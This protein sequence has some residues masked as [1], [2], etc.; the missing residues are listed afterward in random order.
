MKRILIFILL[1]FLG[2]S[3]LSIKVNANVIGATFNPITPGNQFTVGDDTAG[4]TN[5]NWSITINFDNN[6]PI[7][8]N[9]DI[10]IITFPLGFN[11]NSSTINITTN[12]IGA[13][14]GV[15]TKSLNIINI[16]VTGNQTSSGQVVISINNSINTTKAGSLIGN[17]KLKRGAS[18]IINF[19]NNFKVI[20]NLI[21]NIIISP[22]PYNSFVGETKNFVAESY[23]AYGNKR[24]K[25]Q[26]LYG[27]EDKFDWSIIPISDPD[28]G[29]AI[30][31]T[32]NTNTDN[33][34]IQMTDWGH[35]QLKAQFPPGGSYTIYGITDIYIISQISQPKVDVNPP[36][37]GSPAE[38][39]IRFNLGPNGG[40]IGGVDSVTI[41]FPFDTFIP[42]GP[43]YF[44]ALINGYPVSISYVSLRTIRLIFPYSLSNG[45]FVIITFPLNIGIINPSKSGTYNLQVYTSKEP[46]P[47]TSLPYTI[48]YSVISRPKVE[49][50]PNVVDTEAKY[51]I[52]FNTGTAGALIKDYDVITIKFPDDTYIPGVADKNEVTI[53]GFN[54]SDLIIS[55]GRKITLKVSINISN[56]SSV[57]IV[58]TDKFGIKNPTK[59]GDYT[60]QVATSR[61]PTFITSYSYKI[62]ESII[63]DLKVVVS[64]PVTKVEAEYKIS[65]KTGKHGSLLE[66]EEIYLKFPSY[67]KLPNEI[68][69]NLILVNGINLTKSPVVDNSNKILTIKIP[70]KVGN[71]EK[72][73]IIISKEAGIKNPDNPGE[74]RLRAWTSKEKTEVLSS[75]YT[76]IESILSS[77]STKAIPP[78]TKRAISL[79]IVLKTGPGGSLNVNDYIY[80]KF[81]QKVELPQNIK[82]DLIKIKGIPLS[83]SVNISKDK[84]MLTI[85]TPV[86][87]GREED[88]VIY[89]SQDTNIKFIDEGEYYLTVYTSKEPTPINTKTFLIYPQ[90]ETKI[91]L[92]RPEPDGM[93]GFYKTTPVITFTSSSKYDKEPTIFYKWD[94]GPWNEYKGLL[95]PPEGIH[96]LYYF[97]K[98]KLGS[99][100]EI[101]EKSFKVD[102][103]IPKINSINIQDG[104]YFNKEK[105]ELSGSVSESSSILLIQGKRVNIKEDGTFITE[106]EL[107]EG[108][109]SITFILIDI[110]G[111]EF[112]EVIKVIRDTIPPEFIIEYPTPWLVVYDKII[113]IKGKGEIGGKLTVNGEEIL[114]R[115]DG[116]FDGRFELKKAGTNVLDF[117]LIDK[118][119]NTT[120]KSIGVIWN[121][122]VKIELIIGKIEAKVNEYTK[123]LDYPPFIY[124]NR[125]MVP[126]R[127]ISESIGATVD[128][129]SVVRIVTITIENSEGL[130]KILKLSP[131]SNV[132]SLNGKP[133]KMDTSPIIK[134]DRVYLPVRFIMEAFGAKVEWRSLE[135]RILITYPGEN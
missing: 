135:R 100:E 87:I 126:L 92:S 65:F 112:F 115:E 107:F 70:V 36:Y 42:F 69:K 32:T 56:N 128:W 55:T 16:P 41:I 2:I 101:K 91:I 57:K 99:E 62:V 20:P 38:Y 84:S 111:N 73:E 40:V 52:E 95:T 134:N 98:D 15:I 77:I 48:Y 47:V 45:S 75:P 133:Y 10:L 67:T 113:E 83:K 71:E 132:A 89:I 14:F 19:N 124:N 82:Q 53:N 120:R 118:A 127:F 4:K 37:A 66:G 12:T 1:I 76:L 86:P 80:I 23:D 35:I 3:F 11:F 97:A 68:D 49:V 24:T 8:Q 33:V 25:V 117:I 46:T 85:Q 18:F 130:K 129:D 121:P 22:N 74:Y 96:T 102:T 88:F 90:P 58:F 106:V 81:P 63:S 125:T 79:E 60:L 6:L 105:I 78:S 30:F 61:E 114:I 64:P 17:L 131:D 13:T 39:N 51:T 43:P 103:T 5:A 59:S 109:N 44:G 27:W 50:E 108:T 7:L 119:G 122:R 110:A 94:N 54:P 123:I 28:P 31:T 93:N 21:Q 34:S 116:K 9:G 26:T 29:A 72:V 104:M